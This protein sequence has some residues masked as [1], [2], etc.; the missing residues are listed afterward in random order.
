MCLNRV[1]VCTDH[2]SETI[3][4]CT[5]ELWDYTVTTGLMLKQGPEKR[6]LLILTTLY[7]SMRRKGRMN[8]RSEVQHKIIITWVGLEP[9]TSSNILTTGIIDEGGPP[10]HSLFVWI[11]EINLIYWTFIFIV[12]KVQLSLLS[13]YFFILGHWISRLSV[14]PWGWGI[15]FDLSLSGFFNLPK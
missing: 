14:L 2:T 8:Q 12:Y 5:S 13:W 6:C 11:Y 15:C 9:G 3:A 1:W 4:V 7:F 10:N